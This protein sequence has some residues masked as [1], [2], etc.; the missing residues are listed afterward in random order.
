VQKEASVKK[1][2]YTRK[3]Q[4]KAGERMITSPNIGELVG[5]LGV[6]RE[7]HNLRLMATIPRFFERTL[8]VSLNE[9]ELVNF[10]LDIE[11]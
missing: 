6:T 11:Q 2:R 4:R 3:F 1:K 8:Q 9:S 10:L 7:C 5:E